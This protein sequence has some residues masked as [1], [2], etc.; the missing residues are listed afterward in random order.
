MSILTEI[1]FT[2][3]DDTRVL[4]DEVVKNAVQAV[5]S[6]MGPDGCYVTILE[7]NLPKVTK[8]GVSVAKALD[9]NESRRNAIAKI[10]TEP[11][12]KTDIE[13][14]D[15]TTTT[16]FMLGHF[17]EA[18]KN[19]V[20]FNNFR[21]I[22]SWVE[23]VREILKDMTIPGDVNSELF[24]NMLMTTSNYESE[25]VDRILD[26]YRK[27][28]NPNVILQKV[29]SLPKDTIETNSAIY[30]LG[31]YA[32][33]EFRPRTNDNGQKP[34]SKE[35][36]CRVI[37]VD[38]HISKV[39]INLLTKIVKDDNSDTAYAGDIII[40]AR[41]FDPSVV[42]LFKQVNSKFGTRILPYQLNAPGSL[43][44]NVIRDL[45]ELLKINS[46][47]D[48]HDIENEIN[49][50]TGP[51]FILGP[52]S[53]VVDQ[54]N[55]W[56]KETAPKLVQELKK[57]YDVMNVIERQSPIGKNLFDRISRLTG[58]NIIIKVTGTVPSEASERYYR[59][60]DAMK[61]AKTGVIYGILPGIGYGY[62][63]AA[64]QIK[65]KLGKEIKEENVELFNTF[66]NV[67]LAQY[68][69]LSGD[70]EFELG[71]EP[72]FLDLV[73]GEIES[74]PTKVF[75]N[76]AATLTALSGAW[77]TA[78]TLCKLSNIMGRSHSSYVG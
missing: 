28:D 17:Y 6:T 35:A 12:I 34:C 58:N 40:M 7:K 72:K 38:G 9:F 1:T 59:Y 33:D 30:F 11:S 51:G 44:S 26:I 53:L 23:E 69:H 15:G 78:K 73:T 39:D 32:T 70:V 76:A 20:S 68:K 16:V 54:D 56:I 2:N 42:T 27:Y 21:L 61:A 63:S 18:F 55:E 10:I 48:F 74:K 50:Y 19:K 46:V 65:E 13:V 24:R 60:E 67:L 14:G 77:A 47:N 36:G 5:C 4:V 37:V 8:D 75:D 31:G 71:S 29:P 22:D 49:D 66:L 43:G 57:R 3:K 64:H 45:C 25:I 52:N 41:N 62:L